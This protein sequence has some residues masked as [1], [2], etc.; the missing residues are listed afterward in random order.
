MSD[1]IVRIAV[2]VQPGAR[3]NSITGY[4]DGVLRVKVAAPPVEGKANKELIAY[5]SDILDV[6][7]SAITIEKGQTSRNKLISITGMDEA[8]LNTLIG[9]MLKLGTQH[10]LL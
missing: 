3:K 4:S 7:K 2:R 1:D 10:K 5:L 8:R 6:K 9:D